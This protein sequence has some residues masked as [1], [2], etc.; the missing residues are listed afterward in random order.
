MDWGRCFDFNNIIFDEKWHFWLEL[1]LF[2]HKKII[3]LLCKK[4]A[5]S[6]LS[7]PEFFTKTDFLDNLDS[8]ELFLKTTNLKVRSLGLHRFKGWAQVF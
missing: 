6:K 1:K 4:I 2:L 3:I 8:R 5:D 7:S